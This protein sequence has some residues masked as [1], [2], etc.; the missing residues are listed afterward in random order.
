MQFEGSEQNQNASV[1]TSKSDIF[2]YGFGGATVNISYGVITSFLLYF[3]TNNA[4][5]P[6]AAAGVIMFAGRLAGVITDPIAGIIADNTNTKWGKYRPYLMF[7]T[8]FTMLMFFCLFTNYTVSGSSKII[9]YGILYTLYMIGS[10]TITVTFESLVPIMS[11]DLKQRN[12]VV[13]SRQLFG[14]FSMVLVIALTNPIVKAFGGDLNAWHKTIIVFIIVSLIAVA[15]SL[16]GSRKHDVYTSEKEKGISG[17]DF[18]GQLKLVFTCKPILLLICGFGL[19]VLS[20]EVITSSNMY[21]FKYAV[22]NVNLFSVTSIATLPGIILASVSVPVLVNRFGKKNTFIVVCLLN[23]IRPIIF[24]LLQPFANGALVVTMF[25]ISTYFQVAATITI[26][27][28]APDCVEYILLTKGL[29]NAGTVT[30]AFTFMLDLGGAFAGVLVGGILGFV[31]YKAMDIQ[32]ASVVHT[33]IGINS[34]IPMAAMILA[35]LLVKFYPINSKLLE[36][37]KA[38]QLTK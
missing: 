36:D 13:M 34:L 24:L 17:V 12:Y 31:G 33:I 18:V 14:I 35:I 7:M 32:P 30:S 6:A 2:Q 25:A 23:M 8:P 22:K 9:L 10:A 11:T 26:W 21:L 4:F 15:I 29:K 3:L 38:K 20:N 16:R 37:L 19:V 28:M 27:T 1:L 5:V